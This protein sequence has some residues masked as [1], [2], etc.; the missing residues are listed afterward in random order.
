MRELLRWMQSNRTNPCTRAPLD[1][2][3]F[4]PLVSPSLRRQDFLETV[5]RLISVGWRGVAAVERDMVRLPNDDTSSF[6]RRGDWPEVARLFLEQTSLVYI[7]GHPTSTTTRVYQID[8]VIRL[9]NVTP[10][11][12]TGGARFSVQ[13]VC[14][15]LGPAGNLAAYE[16]TLHLL[17]AHGQRADD[18]RLL[19][20]ITDFLHGDTE[21]AQRLAAPIRARAEAARQA[22]PTEDPVFQP[23]LGLDDAG[24]L[25][26]LFARV[27]RISATLART[28]SEARF[29]RERHAVA[30]LD[31]RLPGWPADLQMPHE[32]RIAHEAACLQH[33]EW[34]DP[35][36]ADVHRWSD[37][38][39]AIRAK[40]CRNMK[41][42]RARMA[43]E[44]RRILLHLL[45][46]KHGLKTIPDAIMQPEVLLDARM[47]RISDA[48]TSRQW[49]VPH[50]RSSC[51]DADIGMDANELQQLQ[52]TPSLGDAP[53]YYSLRL[54]PLANA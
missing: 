46:Q 15:V 43:G 20:D 10:T 34:G 45:A 41:F 24:L 5:R 12:A 8:T 52:H 44:L 40:T 21:T 29:Q 51:C 48:S 54:F 2:Q 7:R 30:H 28:P 13:D 22:L 50:G 11:P 33:T 4:E 14:P 1:P 27:V 35:L 37:R 42:E 23:L 47:P 16:E 19:R 31:A 39:V 18:V 38:F 17:A 32:A 9:L 6:L 53:F 25:P 3:Q 26:L 49:Y 36:V